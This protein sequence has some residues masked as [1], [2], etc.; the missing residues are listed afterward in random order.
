MIPE[1]QEIKRVRHRVPRA[2]DACRKMKTKCIVLHS[3]PCETC[4]H[5]SRP[6]TFEAIGVQRE[7]PPTKRE[8]H[9]INFRIRSLEKILKAL[10]PNIDLPSLTLTHEHSQLTMNSSK[11][12]T[13]S[14][15]AGKSGAE[16]TTP[17]TE[18][19]ALCD[20][21]LVFRS[22]AQL[23]ITP[24]DYLED[25]QSGD[26]PVRSAPRRWEKPD[27]SGEPDLAYYM[28][29]ENRSIVER[30]I[31]LHHYD[32]VPDEYYYP[33][34]DLAKSLIEL[35]FKKVHPYEYILHK[36]EFM[37]AYD[38][39]LVQTDNAFRALCYA[40]FAAASRFSS[41]FRVA[42]PLDGMKVDRQAAGAFYAAAC[43]SLATPYTLPST[44]FDLQAMAVLSYFLIG[45]S[46]PMTAWFSTGVFLRQAQDVGAHLAGTPRW[47]T[48]IMKDQLRK[49]AFWFL[50]FREIQLSVSL[51]RAS[52]THHTQITIANP[53]IVDDESLSRFCEEH[54]GK[55]PQS[56]QEL[57]QKNQI[58]Y[59]TTRARKANLAFY[60]L[61]YQ[62]SRSLNTLSALKVVPGSQACDWDRS[63]V[64]DIAQSVD[65]YVRSEISPDARWDP[66]AYDEVDLVTA[67]RF[68]CLIAYLQI[69]VHRHLIASQPQQ[70]LTACLAASKI[71][72][73]VIDHLKNRG[74]LELSATWAPYVITPAALTFLYAVSSPHK[75][76]T[77][78]DRLQS[79]ADAYRCVDI[80]AALAPTTFLAEKLIASLE[81]LLKCCDAES[82]S[83]GSTL[84]SSATQQGASGTSP[85]SFCSSPD[86]GTAQMTCA[87]NELRPIGATAPVIP[88]LSANGTAAFN[89]PDPVVSSLSLEF[90]NCAAPQLDASLFQYPGTGCNVPA[91]WETPQWTPRFGPSAS[92]GDFLP[93][94]LIV[95]NSLHGEH[96]PPLVGPEDRS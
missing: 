31:E 94:T 48:S 69:V 71:M 35:Y 43:T 28:T 27:G 39:G 41:D 25:C 66:E 11:P 63:L 21:D 77:A 55:T 68:E 53:L 23:R 29:N 6:C 87:L 4:K 16:S 52:L 73:N 44:L 40:V 80:L 34:P 76:L 18:S 1:G 90:L 86:T 12:S 83:P 56:I 78:S 5:A 17:Q 50:H 93:Q 85:P 37:R 36:G 88:L 72:L 61:H 60:H 84:W 49:R 24:T 2:C 58:V 10:V 13:S 81:H 7:R 22:V 70:E 74:L 8:V 9:R 59:L 79:H 26:L 67:S 15:L 64:Y 95:P 33:P 45:S 82:L 14:S 54:A 65:I 96:K 38:S 75:F 51:G 32:S 3:I 92:H 30:T 57:S 42:P 62:F 46:S 19:D 91:P 47:E 89:V 20:L